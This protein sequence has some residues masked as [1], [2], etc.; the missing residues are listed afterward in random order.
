MGSQYSH[1]FFD[2]DKTIYDFDRSSHETLLEAFRIN[3]LQGLGISDF[4]KFMDL[5]SKINPPLWEL[6]RKGEIEKEVL[7]WKRFS[8]TLEAFGITNT[9]LAKKIA[10]YYVTESP[11]KKALSP[12]VVETLD[13]FSGKYAMHIITNG[14]EEVQFTKIKAQGIGKYFDTIITSEEA[15]VKK[16]DPYIF[17]YALKKAGASANESLMIGDDLEVDIIGAQ[18]AGLDQVYVNYP[19][20]SHN[21]KISFE[22]FSFSELMRILPAIP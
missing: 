1:L 12:G 17:E 5:Y 14:F 22:I 18:K 9:E 13:Y 4:D 2:L 6:Y 3:D 15:G 7:N 20:I 11:R 8:L 16:P 21:E 10:L 19:R